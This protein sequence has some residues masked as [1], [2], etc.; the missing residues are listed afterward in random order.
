MKS[1]VILISEEEAGTGFDSYPT[2]VIKPALVKK[3]RK[4]RSVNRGGL[5]DSENDCNETTELSAQQSPPSSPCSPH[6]SLSESR[7]TRR[8]MSSLRK[9]KG[10]LLFLRHCN[11]Y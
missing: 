10:I 9:R 7:I 8:R 3:R 2:E 4:T 1:Q 11:R 5:Y 6:S